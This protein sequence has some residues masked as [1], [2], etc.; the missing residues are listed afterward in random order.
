MKYPDLIQR[1]YSQ[2]LHHGIKLGLENSLKLNQ[3]LGNPSHTFPSIHIAGTNGKGS[4]ATKI[5]KTFQLLGL[6]V[7]LYT[8][9]HLSCFRERIKINEAMISEEH[10]E[11]LLPPIFSLT[12][13]E[14]IPATFFEITTLLAFSHFAREKVDIA[15]LETGL[16][17]RLDATNIVIPKLTAITSISLDHTEILGNSLELIAAEKAGII[18]PHIPVVIGPSVPF[19]I[20]EH[21][22]KKNNSPCF[23]VKG[24]FSSFEEE[25]CAI[26]KKCLEVLNISQEAILEGIKTKPSCRMEIVEKHPH[27]VVL[28][29]A[30]NPDGLCNLIKSLK[31][32]FPRKAF[33]IIFGISKNKNALD[34]LKIL[35]EHASHFYPVEAENGRG[36]SVKDLFSQLTFIGVPEHLIILMPT[37]SHAIEHSLNSTSSKQEIILICGS[38]FIMSEARKTLGIIEPSDFFDINE[39]LIEGSRSPCALSHS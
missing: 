18:K 15:I 36:I 22:A 7:G 16:G 11:D 32:K 29:V 9:P 5:A 23:Q 2:N 39:R 30:H 34:C 17:G 14:N 1:L 20:I 12:E 13:Q 19:Q 26:A 4:V 38:F 24:V 27:T 25:N 6:K 10:L 8:S 33:K 28:D 21:F 31:N 35:R 37:I 3:A